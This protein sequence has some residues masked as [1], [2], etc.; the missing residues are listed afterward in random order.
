MKLMAMMA[1]PDDAEIWAGGTICKHAE[2]GDETFILYMAAAE[3]SV[4][5]EEAKRG[6]AILG[7]QVAFAGLTDGQVRDTPETCE[8][9][10]AILMH[11]APDI[12]ITHWIDDVHAD[13]TS[14]AAIVQRVLP[15]VMSHI[16]KAPRLWAC[17]TCFSRGARGSFVADIYVDI[18]AQWTRKL[19]AIRVHQS[20]QPEIWVGLTERQCGLHG[21]RYVPPG[22]QPGLFYAEG[23][24]RVI[25][26][27]Y[28][29]PVPYLDA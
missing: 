5:G 1:H 22:A 15:F 19:A 26:F 18:T 29:A 8:R 23:F 20:Q 6:A 10:S 27:G 21:H 11:F 28:I 7:A 14:T 16:G 17:D 25:P 12:L 24:K 9:V 4:R 2:R 13:H 3:G